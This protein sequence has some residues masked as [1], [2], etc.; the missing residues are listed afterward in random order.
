MKKVPKRSQ[1]VTESDPPIAKQW[2]GQ[3][4]CSVGPVNALV[5]KH[6]CFIFPSHL[7]GRWINLFEKVFPP[8]TR[9]PHKLVI[10]PWCG[11]R[12][13]GQDHPEG[14]ARSRPGWEVC[15]QGSRALW[16]SEFSFWLGFPSNIYVFRFD[17]KPHHHVS[18][19]NM[20]HKNLKFSF[21]IWIFFCLLSHR[22]SSWFF[23]RI[24][25]AL[26][27]VEWGGQFTSNGFF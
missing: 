17:V 19:L 1:K 23:L 14:A 20:G 21:K 22:P 8:S 10:S 26:W 5:D 9:T 18:F 16:I 3:A 15:T 27:V 6:S 13:R 24:L 7:F 4:S 12:R 25:P 11:P 2:S